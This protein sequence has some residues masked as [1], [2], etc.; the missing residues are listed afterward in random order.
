LWWP[1][2]VEEI[3]YW[4]DRFPHRMHYR[5]GSARHDGVPIYVVGGVEVLGAGRATGEWWEP[6]ELAHLRGLIGSVGVPP[7]LQ[8]IVYDEKL[9]IHLIG[10]DTEQE[11]MSAVSSLQRVT[12]E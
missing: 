11:I 8:A 2:D 5:I 10:Y 12:P 9:A 1:E 6:R 7:R 3:D 4:L